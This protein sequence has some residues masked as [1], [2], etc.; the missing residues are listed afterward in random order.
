MPEMVI[1]VNSPVESSIEELDDN[2]TNINSIPAT[3][4]YDT[5]YY[6]EGADGAPFSFEVNGTDAQVSVYNYQEYEGADAV[7][8][9][10]PV[11]QK[12]QRNCSIKGRL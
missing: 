10:Y 7:K 5:W 9:E 3:T 2:L 12:R 11:E 8:T 1:H 6:F 4:K